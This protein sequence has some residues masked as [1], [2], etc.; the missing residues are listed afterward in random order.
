MKEIWKNIPNYEGIYEISSFGKIKNTKSGKILKLI[1]NHRGY[2]KTNLSKNGKL[3][4]VFPHRLVAESFIENPNNLPQ[5]NH[6]DGNKENNYV[7]NLE[8]CT[9][10]HN[11]QH[12]VKNGLIKTKKVLMIDLKN[13]KEYRFANVMEASRRTKVN[14]KQIYNSIYK[15]R[16]TNNK[17]W[18]FE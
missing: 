7:F 8:F 14:R 16:M 6:K 5:V 13:N 4:T 9:E 2:L 12:A 1:K 18:S 17:I 10:K 15:K 3:K 11:M